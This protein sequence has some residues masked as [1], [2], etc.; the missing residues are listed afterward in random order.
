M[1]ESTETL[2]HDAHASDM[3]DEHGHHDDDHHGHPPDSFY[4]K[5]AL[6]LGVF[7]AIEV[8][9]YFF[10]EQ[11]GHWPLIILLSVLMVIKFAMVGWYFMHL[12]YD[13][14]MYTKMFVA[15][16]ILAIAVYFIMLFAS[17]FFG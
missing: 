8:S 10:E 12:K 4:V 5:I 17:N 15:G 14:Q 1:N 6:I 9:T 13:A 3:L 11:L 2:E 16:L 7:T